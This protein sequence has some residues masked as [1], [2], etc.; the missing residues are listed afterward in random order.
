ME[1]LSASV[2]WLTLSVDVSPNVSYEVVSG[3]H[4]GFPNYEIYINEEQIHGYS[5]GAQTPS[6]LFHPMEFIIPP[7]SGTV[8]Q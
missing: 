2:D 1:H 6:S 5:H 3:A 8:R 4:D 7:S